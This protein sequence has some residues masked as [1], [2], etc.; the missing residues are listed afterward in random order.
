M[1]GAEEEKRTRT[2]GSG[3]RER[4]TRG[5]IRRGVRRKGEE[6]RTKSVGCKDEGNENE[7]RGRER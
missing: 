2:R 1:R 3:R 7:R 4:R 6:K 5:E